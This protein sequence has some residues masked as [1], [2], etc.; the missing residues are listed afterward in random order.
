MHSARLSV[1]VLFSLLLAGFD[2]PQRNES[3]R[4]LEPGTP[5]ED[6]L[7]SDQT[8]SL[9]IA[10][11]G[12]RYMQVVVE[13]NGLNIVVRLRGPKDDEDM[14]VESGPDDEGSLSISLISQDRGAYELAVQR[15]G[16]GGRGGALFSVLST[17]SSMEPSHG[18][19][20]TASATISAS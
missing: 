20:S 12:G 5:I 18:T 6:M 3:A 19:A 8:T 16:T 17:T 15:R 14:Q 13:K 11:D 10:V 4:A 1:V 2:R 9:E 7:G